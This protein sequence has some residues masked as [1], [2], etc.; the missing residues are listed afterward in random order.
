MRL[1]SDSDVRNICLKNGVA[2]LGMGSLKIKMLEGCGWIVHNGEDI[3]IDAGEEIELEASLYP[4]VISQL[5]ANQAIV[6]NVEQVDLEKR[7]DRVPAHIGLKSL[8]TSLSN[9]LVSK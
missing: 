2:N 9:L 3:F 6:F 7:L 8:V 1:A 4:I 5:S